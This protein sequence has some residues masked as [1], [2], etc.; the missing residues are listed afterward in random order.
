MREPLE[1]G[2]LES[3]ELSREAV[4]GARD[5]FSGVLMLVGTFPAV[6]RGLVLVFPLND[7]CEPVVE[8]ALVAPFDLLVLV[9]PEPV[10]EALLPTLCRASF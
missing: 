4:E 2:L 1:L 6:L 7:S 3:L 5:F 8:G 10:L 9:L